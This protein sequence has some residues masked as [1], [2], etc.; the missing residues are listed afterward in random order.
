M[1]KVYFASALANATVQFRHDC[2]EIKE[3]LKGKY[4]IKDY[5]GYVPEADAKMIYEHDAQQ[6][7]NAEML[8]AECSYPSLGVGYEIGLALALGKQVI[9]IAKEGSIVSK[10]ITGNPSIKFIWYADPKDLIVKL[11]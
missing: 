3:L 1:K 8:I 5:F 7:R 6:I 9:A 2:D 10:M 11:I 4:V